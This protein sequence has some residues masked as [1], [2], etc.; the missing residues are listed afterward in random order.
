MCLSF[1]APSHSQPQHTGLP[2]AL[3]ADIAAIDTV[4]WLVSLDRLSRGRESPANE[5]PSPREQDY[6]PTSSPHARASKIIKAAE[7]ARCRT[8]KSLNII[9][10][11][12]RSGMCNHCLWHLGNI[13]SC[14]GNCSGRLYVC[15]SAMVEG[16]CIMQ[17][18]SKGD[19]LPKI[20]LLVANNVTM[21]T[22]LI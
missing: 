21:A 14:H 9:R 10:S 7:H 17:I 12:P 19:L 16:I 8:K 5:E 6:S 11:F 3:Q 2:L 4:F 18:Q 13:Q 22:V 1:H 15:A 20:I